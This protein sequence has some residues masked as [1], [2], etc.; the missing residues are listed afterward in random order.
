MKLN[1]IEVEIYQAILKDLDRDKEYQKLNAK[2][3]SF[4]P[5]S[6]YR[7]K[8]QKELDD[9]IDVKIKA[10]AKRV[11]RD[12]MSFNELKKEMSQEDYEKCAIQTDMIIY[13]ADM[14]DFYSNEIEQ[15]INPYMLNGKITLYEKVKEAGQGARDVIKFLGTT[16]ES[17]QDEIANNADE[18]RLRFESV[19]KMF[20]KNNKL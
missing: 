1:K 14:I 8:A 3:D 12:R 6:V 18:M 16:S 15:T 19:Y 17:Y 7:F 4:H 9:Y 5:T 20:K 11:D 13:L 2:V 10:F